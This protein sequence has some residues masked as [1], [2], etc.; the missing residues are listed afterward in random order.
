MEVYK[1]LSDVTV[2]VLIFYLQSMIATYN[3]VLKLS[4][5]LRL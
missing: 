3:Q 2:A 5:I 4:A 1:P